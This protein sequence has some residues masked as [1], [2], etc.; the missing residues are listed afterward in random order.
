MVRVIAKSYCVAV[1]SSSSRPLRL[2][3]C[4]WEAEN[5]PSACQPSRELASLSLANSQLLTAP[6]DGRFHPTPATSCFWKNRSSFSRPAMS[7]IEKTET[8]PALLAVSS[9]LQ[10]KHSR[11]SEPPCPSDLCHPWYLRNILR[12]C[13]P[14]F[15]GQ[16]VTIYSYSY[17][18]LTSENRNNVAKNIQ[19]ARFKIL[20][21]VTMRGTIFWDVAPCRPVKVNVCIHL[22]D[23]CISE[24][25]N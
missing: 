17:S 25:R 12:A 6:D 18:L 22:Q 23:R 20:T 16:K 9:V 15:N 19:S 11:F 8:S 7:T 21:R 10:P 24:A 4:Q 13:H 14:S 5:L 3:R 1:S 2:S